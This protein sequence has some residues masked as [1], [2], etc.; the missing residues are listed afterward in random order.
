M[1]EAK[2]I[3]EVWLGVQTVFNDTRDKTPN[4]TINALLEE[5]TMQELLEAFAAVTK[6]KKHDGRIWGKQREEMEKIP[7]DPLLE[8]HSHSNPLLRTGLD[9][10]HTVHIDQMIRALLKVRESEVV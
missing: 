9:N 5:F 6:Y 2:R 10:I 8:E 4:D 1:I 3:A 7:T